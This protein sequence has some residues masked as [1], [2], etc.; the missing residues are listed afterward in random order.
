[1]AVGSLFGA[2]PAIAN[3]MIVCCLIVFVYAII[4]VSFFKGQFHQ[5]S[6]INHGHDLELHTDG[7]R[8]RFL[9]EFNVTS[10]EPGLENDSL[11]L[12]NLTSDDTIS[13]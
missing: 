5:C 1:M 6:L 7:R 12:S 9:D 8:L 10:E 11:N 13:N 4:G 3:G 2:L